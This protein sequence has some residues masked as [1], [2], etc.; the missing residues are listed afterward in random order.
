MW[1][2]RLWKELVSSWWKRFKDGVGWRFGATEIFCFSFWRWGKPNG[3]ECRWYLGAKGSL[4]LTASKKT[5]EKSY[6]RKEPKSS[7]NLRSSPGPSKVTQSGWNSD[8]NQ[9][10]PKHRPPPCHAMPGF[11]HT[12]LW[13]AKW[14]LLSAAELMVICYTEIK[15]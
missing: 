1:L 5:G 9:W 7:N 3:K 10:D 12:E 11:L 8:F 13:I 15:N 4:Q 6:N 2:I 14:E